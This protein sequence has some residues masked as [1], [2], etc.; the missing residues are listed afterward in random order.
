MVSCTLQAVLSH[1]MRARGSGASKSSSS[2]EPWPGQLESN[3]APQG[4]MLQTEPKLPDQNELLIADNSKQEVRQHLNARI[5]Y[6]T[7]ILH[8][9]EGTQLWSLT[10]GILTVKTSSLCSRRSC[11]QLIPFDGALNDTLLLTLPSIKCRSK[12]IM[13]VWHRTNA[14]YPS[15]VQTFWYLLTTPLAHLM[16]R[17]Q[18]SYLDRRDTHI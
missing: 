13:R 5:V 6:C 9:C 15:E 3:V 17:V 10:S 16:I 18:K 2:P 4:D 7:S 11:S 1:A 14:L 8:R 12:N